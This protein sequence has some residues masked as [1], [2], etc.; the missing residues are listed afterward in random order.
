MCVFGW[1]KDN[2]TIGLQ[3]KQKSHAKN[4]AEKVVTTITT[5]I[6]DDEVALADNFTPKL[7]KFIITTTSFRDVK[8]QKHIYTLNEK[9][10]TKRLPKIE[11]WTWEIFEEEIN[12]H[13]ELSY[14]YYKNILIQFNQ[15]DKDKHILTLLR[16]SVSRPAFSTPFNCENNCD[17]FIN[18]IADTQRAFTTGKLYDRDQNLITSAFPAKDLSK[19]LD[20]NEINEVEMILQKI[21]NFTTENLTNGNIQQRPNFLYFRNDWELKISETLNHDRGLIIQKLNS[22]LKRHEMEPM[23]SRFERY[24]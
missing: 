24:K 6:I 5:K 23:D 15:Y 7:E 16:H 9:R 1:D 20:R 10:K 13:S 2:K 22:I 12:R 19:L 17:D 21:R 8:L 18:A 11:L 4:E 14:F 3:C